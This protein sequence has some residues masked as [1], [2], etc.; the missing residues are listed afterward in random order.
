MI[1]TIT[2]IRLEKKLNQISKMVG[3]TPLFPI[4]KLH[5]NKDVRIFAKIEW[6]QLGGSVKS[7]PAFQIIKDAIRSGLLH[8]EKEILDAS[9]GNT[10]IAFAAI[11]ASLGLKVTIC[12]PEN[13]SKERKTLLKAFGANIVYTSRFGSTDEARQIALEMYNRNPERYFYADQ[14][15]NDS[16]WKAHYNGT[17]EEIFRQTRGEV[18]HFVAGL[19]TSGTFTGVGRKLKKLTTNVRMIALQPD[20]VMHGLEGWKHYETAIVPGIY[21]PDIQDDHL[22]IGTQDAYDLIRETSKAEGLLI[23]PSAA[24]NLAGALKLSQQLTRGTIVTVFADDASKYG[25]VLKHIFS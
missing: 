11:G 1:A 17:A 24:A 21:D 13:A 3:N 16:N 10:G 5:A 25:D 23:S 6:Q 12:L 4:T 22:E 2:D 7:R 18:T 15:N 8:G 19:G 14:Y 20:T 9:S